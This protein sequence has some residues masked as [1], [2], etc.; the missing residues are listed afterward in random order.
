MDKIF[1]FYIKII[2]VVWDYSNICRSTNL[3]NTKFQN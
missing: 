3:V 1:D 2:N